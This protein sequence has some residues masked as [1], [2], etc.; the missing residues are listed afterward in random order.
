M[1]RIDLSK[2]LMQ[3]CLATNCPGYQK[4]DRLA[5]LEVLEQH[6][7]TSNSGSFVKHTYDP[8]LLKPYHKWRDDLRAWYDARTLPSE[9]KGLRYR[10]REGWAAFY[11]EMGGQLREGERIADRVT[12]EYD[13]ARA[14]AKS[15]LGSLYRESDYISKAE[16]RSRFSASFHVQPMPDSRNFMVELAEGQLEE[17]KA[18]LDRR[19]EELTQGIPGQLID[20]VVGPV[21]VIT[22]KLSKDNSRGTTASVEALV[23]LCTKQ[24]P[25]LNV[26]RDQ[27][28]TD[29]CARVVRALSAYD[30]ESVR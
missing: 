9:I 15:S 29:L 7:A 10:P 24:I 30:L 13:G 28:V 27:R 2:S 3:T 8:A 25:M 5:S 18:Q 23:E 17:I 16:F 19:M 14:D 26:T 22:D 1:G 4:T 11:A 21:Q 6:Q 12:E 20:M